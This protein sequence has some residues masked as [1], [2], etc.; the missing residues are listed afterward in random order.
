ASGVPRAK[1]APCAARAQECV[2]GERG[3]GSC[4]A[5]RIRRERR[6]HPTRARYGRCIL[7]DVAV[8]SVSMMSHP[9][10][11]PTQTRRH[12]PVTL[13]ERHEVERISDDIAQLA[14]K[15]RTV[16]TIVARFPTGTE[17]DLG[18]L[19]PRALEVRRLQTVPSES[20]ATLGDAVH[21]VLRTAALVA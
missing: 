17:P 9:P 20:P 3:G 12:R 1:R 7:A 6:T 8:S 18:P 15:R 4:S 13:A 11:P 21:R 5:V 2:R 16:A 19:V 10:A 14:G